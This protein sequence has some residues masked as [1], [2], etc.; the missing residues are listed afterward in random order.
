[1]GVGETVGFDEMLPTEVVE[2]ENVLGEPGTELPPLSSPGEL[3]E[4]V[5]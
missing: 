2:E 4:P 5:G 1:M 3:P